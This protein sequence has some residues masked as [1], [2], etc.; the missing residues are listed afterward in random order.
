MLSLTV[1]SGDYI[2][3]GDNVVIQV[4]RAG[5]VFRVAI[6]APKEMPIERAKVHEQTAET[7]ECI[8]RVREKYKK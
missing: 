5:D 1:R 2:T 6:D 8:R 3:I 4:L 7:P